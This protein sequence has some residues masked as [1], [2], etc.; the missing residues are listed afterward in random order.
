MTRVVCVVQARQGSS[1]LPGKALRPLKGRPMIAHVLER[2][3]AIEG[4]DDV[5]LATS[6]RD[7]DDLL[8]DY[9][10][11][12]RVAVVRGSEQ[13]VLERFWVAASL[14]RADIVMRVTGDCPFLDPAIAR[15]VL[16]L[17]R[18]AHAMSGTQY[19]WNDTLHSGW[20]DGTDVEV[21]SIGVLEEAH[22]KARA[23]RDREHV[24]SWIRDYHRVETF[25]C[26]EDHS[27]IKL[28]VDRPE[29]YDLAQAIA[30]YLHEGDFS[31]DATLAAYR[32]VTCRQM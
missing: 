3:K 14:A 2:A 11:G 9:V 1:R 23:Q 7:V 6:L 18:I 17:Y 15:D 22:L 29:D 28:S 5:V 4:L 31:L 27:Q 12:L 32:E 30:S 26:P 24:T 25:Y 13:D 16:A 21:F 8:A 20:P 19:F 10:A